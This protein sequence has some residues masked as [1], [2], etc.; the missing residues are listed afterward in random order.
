MDLVGKGLLLDLLDT[1]TALT[2]QANA[3]KT[4]LARA[5]NPNKAFLFFFTVV[6]SGEEEDIDH[7]VTR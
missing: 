6:V 4:G 1:D 2:G 7:H 3:E 5:A